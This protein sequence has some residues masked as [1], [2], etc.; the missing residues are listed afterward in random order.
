MALSDAVIKSAMA[1][2]NKRKR[3]RDDGGLTHKNVRTRVGT[4]RNQG[5]LVTGK[6][7]PVKPAVV[8]KIIQKASAGG[9]Y[10]S[11]S[12]YSPLI[13]GKKSSG[14]SIP[15]RGVNYIAPK[16]RKTKKRKVAT[17]VP[18]YRQ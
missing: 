2:K 15:H 8:S 5:G 10:K 1:R 9:E 3:T 4:S 6:S 7:T 12:K 17:Q 18:S 13:S 14:V 16:L 11:T